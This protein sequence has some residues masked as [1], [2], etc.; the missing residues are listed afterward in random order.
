[1][2]SLPD[3]RL[4][5]AGA[6]A[7]LAVAGL[8]GCTATNDLLHSTSTTHVDE[9]TDM[10]GGAPSWVPEDASDIRI[11]T[12]TDGGATSVLLVSA[13][14]LNP[15]C[16]ETPRLSAPTV[17]VEGAPDVYDVKAATVFSCGD[18]TVA[19]SP[20][21]WYGWTPATEDEAAPTTTPAS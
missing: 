16:V 3:R 11:V 21:G 1:M 4:L 9:R 18:W 20:D 8:A 13:A 7:L 2:T 10:P 17:E 12:G 15:A 6:A 5:T 14:D 19:A